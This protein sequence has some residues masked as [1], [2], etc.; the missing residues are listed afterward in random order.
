MSWGALFFNRL[1]SSEKSN[2]QFSEKREAYFLHLS[3]H[4]H[5]FLKDSDLDHV[6]QRLRRLLSKNVTDESSHLEKRHASPELEL[7]WRTRVT[8][9]GSLRNWAFLGSEKWFEVEGKLRR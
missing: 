1:R 4:V 3:F 7:E 6:A 5:R 8:G 2:E 9:L